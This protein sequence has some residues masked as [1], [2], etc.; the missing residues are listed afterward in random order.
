MDA[1]ALDVHDYNLGVLAALIMGEGCIDQPSYTPRIRV[2][3]ADLPV[4]QW[5]HERF[6]GT[7]KPVQA[8]N[9][10]WMWEWYLGSVL[11]LELLERLLP[12]L[13]GAKLR[14][15]EILFELKNYP[16]KSETNQRLREEL[17]QLKR[18][19]YE[20]NTTV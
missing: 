16:R 3:M 15:A 11:A 7:L 6:R 9:G 20:P 18:I 4:V 10:R 19:S 2:K 8:S 12:H 17:A 5:I 1:N 13:I 14:Q